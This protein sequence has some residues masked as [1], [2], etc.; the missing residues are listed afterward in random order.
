MIYNL[1]RRD[2]ERERERECI[3]SRR[4]IIN[5]DYVH[6]IHTVIGQIGIPF[7]SKVD[8]V[9]N[10]AEE[11]E[12]CYN[13]W[14]VDLYMAVFLIFVLILFTGLSKENLGMCW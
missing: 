1:G 14:G 6:T 11:I 4:N 7:H 10:L 5:T 8:T 9:Q 12:V 3:M 13:V 2:K